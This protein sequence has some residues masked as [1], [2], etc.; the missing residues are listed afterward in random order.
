VTGPPERFG[1]RSREWIEE[2]PATAQLRPVVDEQG[3]SAGL[4]A[5]FLEAQ[6][7]GFVGP[8]DVG[9]HIVHA[10][11]FV[12]AV[13]A[14]EATGPAFTG[15]ALDL[16]TGAGIPGLILAAHWPA[17]RWLLIDGKERRMGPLE[18]AID[19]LGLSDRVAVR[20]ER[21]EVLGHEPGLRESFD[22][23]VSRSFGPPAATAESGAALLEIGG[24]LAVS[25][26]PVAGGTAGGASG[27]KS[28]RGSPRW[29][30]E[31]LRA[32]GL[33]RSAASTPQVQV[34]EKVA[35]TPDDRPRRVG[36]PAKRPLF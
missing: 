33:V 19:Q 10:Q 11:R 32:L 20:C 5:W 15:R 23:V 25:E 16:G 36:V 9:D 7:F 26:P 17:S 35:A 8:A 21:A 4:L 14:V 30:D 29:A 34:F 12:E 18:D 22:L 24:H 13:E 28:G 3:L 2:G 31:P 6:R 27:S 1:D